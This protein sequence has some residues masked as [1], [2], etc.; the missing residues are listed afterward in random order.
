MSTLSVISEGIRLVE[1]IL[2]W[3][4][5]GVSDEEIRRRLSDPAGV[6][7][8]LIDAAKTRKQKLEEFIRNG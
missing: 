6:A 8:H 2:Q 5:D 7:Q 3:V 1:Q 4:H